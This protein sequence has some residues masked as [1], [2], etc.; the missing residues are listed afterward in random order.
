MERKEI[1]IQTARQIEKYADERI[2]GQMDGRNGGLIER[3]LDRR[4][5]G[6]TDRNNIWGQF[7]NTLPIIAC[8]KY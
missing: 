3:W 4:F 2:D 7:N 1:D 8:N 5:D 6:E